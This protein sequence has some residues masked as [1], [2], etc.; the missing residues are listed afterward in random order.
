MTQA[1]RGEGFANDFV[2]RCIGAAVFL[3]LHRI[4][5][6]NMFDGGYYGLIQPEAM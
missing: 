4:I 1:G 5:D 3:L 2:W 6:G